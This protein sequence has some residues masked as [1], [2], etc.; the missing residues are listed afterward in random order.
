MPFEI[1]PKIETN[2]WVVAHP[3]VADMLRSLVWRLRQLPAN[4]WLYSRISLEEGHPTRKTRGL[5]E[6]GTV[7]CALGHTEWGDREMFADALPRNIYASFFYGGDCERGATPFLAGW[8]ATKEDVAD[9][10]DRWL[11]T[12]EIV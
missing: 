3:R 5:A 4:R 12:G 7:G 1:A 9:R 8:F 2:P 10:I 11:A 6:C